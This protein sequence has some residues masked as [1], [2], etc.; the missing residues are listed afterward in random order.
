VV[1]LNMQM[2]TKAGFKHRLGAKTARFFD[3]RGRET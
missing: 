1:L 3:G 2:H